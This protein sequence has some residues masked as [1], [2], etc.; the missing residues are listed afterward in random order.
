M[1]WSSSF[2]MSI[3]A[4]FLSLRRVRVHRCRRRWKCRS[5]CAVKTFSKSPRLLTIIAKLSI[6]S[7]LFRVY[8]RVA[9]A[10]ELT[11]NLRF[12]LFDF[13]NDRWRPRHERAETRLRRTPERA[14]ERHDAPDEEGEWLQERNLLQIFRIKFKCKSDSNSFSVAFLL[15]PPPATCSL[16]NRSFFFPCISSLAF[17]SF[18]RSTLPQ[19]RIPN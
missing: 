19:T 5:R 1:K 4:P 3:G 15:R 6:H 12:L 8:W 18:S 10:L 11:T 17:V 14:T 9:N 16:R 2:R 13:C 7:H